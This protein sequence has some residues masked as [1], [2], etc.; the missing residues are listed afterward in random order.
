M[1]PGEKVNGLDGDASQLLKDGQKEGLIFRLTALSY[2]TWV[3]LSDIN[4]LTQRSR[5]GPA[6]WCFAGYCGVDILIIPDFKLLFTV[7]KGK[8]WS[9]LL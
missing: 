3:I 5:G 2:S 9:C 4:K 8:A 6:S 7:E 1:H